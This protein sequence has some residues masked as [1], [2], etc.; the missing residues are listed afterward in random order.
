MIFS[1][2]WAW[3]FCTNHGGPHDR[4]GKGFLFGHAGVLKS[5]HIPFLRPNSCQALQ[6]TSVACI[7]WSVH[8]QDISSSYT[9]ETVLENIRISRRNLLK[10]FYLGHRFLWLTAKKKEK[11]KDFGAGS[12]IACGVTLETSYNSF[13]DPLPSHTCLSKFHKAS[14]F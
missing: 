14:D 1:R 10:T 6:L 13:L 8:S 4:K 11:E 3:L 2:T 7:G 12:A 5:R 9:K